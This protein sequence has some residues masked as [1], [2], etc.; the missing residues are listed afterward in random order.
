MITMII[1]VLF[2]LLFLGIPVY[3]SMSLAAISSMVVFGN[4]DMM[5]ALQRVFDGID[6][7]SLMS[8]PFYILASDLM[9]FGG[10][11]K[12]I[13]NFADCLIGGFRGSMALTTEASCMFFGALSGS[14]P[15]TVSA[16]GS[17]M[18]PDLLKGGYG[19]KF[20]TGLV[21]ASGSV[22][23][24]I[25]PSIT[26]IV[27]GATT[28]VS[29][30]ALFMAGIG[31]G[32]LYGL[33]SLTYCYWYAIKHNI[34]KSPK[35]NSA[36]KWA[37]TKE[38]AWALGVPVIILG[39][40]AMGMFTPVEAAGVAVVYTFF[41]GVFIY[42]ELTMERLREALVKSSVTIAQLM[43]L[44]GAASLFGWALTVTYV[45]QMLTAKLV[46][47]V[48]SPYV[49]L[50]ILNIMFLIA[51]MF[52]DGSA[53]ITIMAPLFYGP[54][55]SLGIDPVHLG[56]MAIVNFAIGMFTPPFGLNLFVGQ[57]VTHMPML[58]IYKAVLPFIA[59]CIVALLLI[60][61]IPEVSLFFPKL[62]GYVGSQSVLG[63]F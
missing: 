9:I 28:G 60:T 33:L 3:I 1:S 23:I 22:A 56:A 29:V 54:A 47:V 44:L 61:Y 41:V 48:Q 55:I 19:N 63:T 6:K 15:A 51:G 11:S 18:Y 34:P 4:Y 38:A 7:F 49:F 16:I 58:E 36:E 13:L 21:T 30:G 20:A 62:A 27:F 42:K 46:E 37:A 12:R 32:L 2:I 59:V 53:A 25:P 14:S 35:K 40:I 50:A 57:T 8:M 31:A 43:I 52:I 26:F 5:I 17:L 10:M 24:I 39:G 45:P